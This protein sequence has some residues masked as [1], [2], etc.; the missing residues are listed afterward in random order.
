MRPLLGPAHVVL[1][2]GMLLHGCNQGRQ[3][4]PSAG[5]PPDG[6]AVGRPAPEIVGEDLDGAPLRLSDFRG[7]VV[8]LD[9][10]ATW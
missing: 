5:E 7:Q 10:W 4:P 2:L 9:F 8:V 6:L 1:A 3:P